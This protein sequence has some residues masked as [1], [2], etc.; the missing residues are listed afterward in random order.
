VS[1]AQLANG[2]LTGAFSATLPAPAAPVAPVPG[3]PAPALLPTI[4]AK[5]TLTGG[6]ATALDLPYAFPITL[7]SGRINAAI[8]LAASGYAPPVWLAT[9]T[10]NASLAATGGSLNGFNLPEIITALHASRGRASQ[11]RAASLTGVTPFDHLSLTSVLNSGIATLT[12]ASLQSQ[13]GTATATGNIDLPDR[14]VTL[15]LTLQP[16]VPAPPKLTLTLDGSWQAPRKI[17]AIKPALG[18]RP[19]KEH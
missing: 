17:A 10:G 7:P 11:L 5:A 6:D 18:W 4:T 1:H 9:L 8:D 16:A 12:G 13:S 19:A 2:N 15:T 14:G 3:K